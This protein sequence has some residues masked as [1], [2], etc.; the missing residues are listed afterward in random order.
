MDAI[1]VELPGAGVGQVGM[2]DEVG[3]LGHVDPLRLLLGVG[4]VKRRRSRPEIRMSTE[5]SRVIDGL[6]QG[7]STVGV[8]PPTVQQAGRDDRNGST[9]PSVRICGVQ[10]GRHFP[11]DMKGE[12]D[13][14]VH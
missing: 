1:A 3:L 9:V 11:R 13:H 14:P 2:P 7:T 5:H 6:R 4:R 10:Y 12:L 8:I